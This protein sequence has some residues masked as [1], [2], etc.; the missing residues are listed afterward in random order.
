MF[1]ATVRQH[2]LEE[3]F[4][5][6]SLF[7]F[8]ATIAQSLEVS[9]VPY[10]LIRLMAAVTRVVTNNIEVSFALF[11]LIIFL[12]TIT[13]SLE[14]S[15]TLEKVEK[16]WRVQERTILLNESVYKV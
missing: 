1:V 15:G 14:A 8:V 7:T 4:A 5:S 10:S 16:H 9:F 12:A 6:S 2:S 3:T 11:S 13:H